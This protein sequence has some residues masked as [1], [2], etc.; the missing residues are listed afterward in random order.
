MRSNFYYR[1]IVAGAFAALVVMCC[2]SSC[3]KANKFPDFTQITETS[4]NGALAQGGTVDATDWKLNDVFTDDE[5]ALF[6]GASNLGTCALI[7]N[8]QI[9]GYPNANNGYFVLSS[10]ISN[11]IFVEIRIVDKN[12]NVLRSITN[13]AS[14]QSYNFLLGGLVANGDYVR[15]Y[16]KFIT[17]TCEYKGHGDL[18]IMK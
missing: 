12:F 1:S 13:S 11:A 5:N 9:I 8:E 14:V 18:K 16:Y 3:N 17:P 7:P 10:N 4:I 2:I 6:G 15:V